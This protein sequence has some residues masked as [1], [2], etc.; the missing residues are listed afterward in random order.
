M[1]DNTD[2][3]TDTDTHTHTH[4]YI[5]TQWNITQPEK[6]NEIMPFSAT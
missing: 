5:C 2:T 3:D 4:T 6:R 1:I